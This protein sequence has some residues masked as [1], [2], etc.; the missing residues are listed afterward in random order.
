VAA[1]FKFGKYRGRDIEEIRFRDPQYCRW[2][3]E[4]VAGFA[5]IL[6]DAVSAPVKQP[7]KRREGKADIVPPKAYPSPP[8][9]EYADNRPN[10]VLAAIIADHALQYCHPL[11][12]HMAA[13]EPDIYQ[14]GDAPPY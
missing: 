7:K 11:H 3:A 12:M 10:P 5:A 2:C 4:N 14:P 6:R 8:R 13:F 9:R 1:K